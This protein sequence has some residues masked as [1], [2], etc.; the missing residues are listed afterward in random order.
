MKDCLNRDLFK[1]SKFKI[2]KDYND[3]YIFDKW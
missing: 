1:I 3:W 2:A